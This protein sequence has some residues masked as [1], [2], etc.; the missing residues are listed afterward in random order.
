[1]LHDVRAC[2][3]VCACVC[4]CVRVC[5]CVGGGGAKQLTCNAE[6]LRFLVA[7]SLQ[8]TASSGRSSGRSHR[9]IRERQSNNKEKKGGREREKKIINKEYSPHPFVLR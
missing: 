3:P 1:M 4:A 6:G 5:V 2:G 9:K 8:R 7:F